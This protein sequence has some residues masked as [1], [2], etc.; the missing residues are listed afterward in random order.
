MT[1][2]R[3]SKERREEKMVGIAEPWRALVCW[4]E[5]SSRQLRTAGAWSPRSRGA[6]QR[7]GVGRGCRKIPT[8]GQKVEMAVWGSGG[9]VRVPL[10]TVGRGKGGASGFFFF[11]LMSLHDL[12]SAK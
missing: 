4:T 8:C 12:S 6:V 7:M 11:F 5:R 2:C 10:I 9:V 3:E 1:L